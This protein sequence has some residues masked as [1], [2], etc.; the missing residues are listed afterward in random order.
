MANMALPDPAPLPPLDFAS[1]A[2]PIEIIPVGERLVRIHR[3]DLGPLFFGA[4]GGNRFDDPDH[5]FGVCYLSHSFEGAFAE[6]AL[7]SVGARFVALSFL[8]LRSIS[9]IEVSA[10]I[11][12][13]SVHGP[14]LAKL[15]ATAV[16]TSGPH[17]IAQLWSRAIYDHPA[18]PDG[19]AYR[20][21]HDNGELC[22]ALFDRAEPSLATVSTSPLTKDRPRL[23]GMLQRYDV[24]LG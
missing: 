3:S 2:L 11:R 9:L 15:G 17:A 7:R 20:S 18:A 10:E 1:R 5:R 23:A 13:V 6:T 16:V 22:V 4:T 19:V 14:G 21:N 24:G 12:L 8:E